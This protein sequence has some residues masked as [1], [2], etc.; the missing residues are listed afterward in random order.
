LSDLSGTQVAYECSGREDLVPALRSALAGDGSAAR[1]LA[2][3][4]YLRQLFDDQLIGTSGDSPTR[5]HVDDFAEYV[6][7]HLTAIGRRRPEPDEPVD[8]VLEAH[9]DSGGSLQFRRARTAAE[10]PGRDR[11]LTVALPLLG[12]EA[13]LRAGIES[14]LRQSRAGAVELLLIDDGS[15]AMA[16][17]LA[18]SYG[19]RSGV[20]TLAP[21]TTPGS[22]AA[23]AR[24]AVAA[25]RADVLL[26][27]PG[28]ALPEN[29]L[30]ELRPIRADSGVGTVALTMDS[31]GPDSAPALYLSRLAIDRAGLPGDGIAED[32][33]ARCANLGLRHVALRLTAP[34]PTGGQ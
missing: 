28:T 31:A 22:G 8:E 3:Q 25:G 16:T 6:W 30:A 32:F 23:A 34:G 29:G 4:R 13:E 14:V 33:I 10:A 27:P 21:A 1:R 5:L 17:R 12:I 15:S 19:D 24:A 26:L 11:P 2:G 18:A 7:R 9:A 20:R